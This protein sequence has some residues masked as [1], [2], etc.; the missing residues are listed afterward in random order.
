MKRYFRGRNS[1]DER[2]PKPNLAKRVW[3][4]DKGLCI[5]CGAPAQVLDH[6]IRFADNSPTVS[7]NLVCSCNSCNLWRGKHPNDI[8]LLTKAICH[9]LDCGEDT[10]WMDEFYE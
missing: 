1:S 5:Y 7:S 9:L 3:G 4:R 8:M 6:I 2:S 10:K